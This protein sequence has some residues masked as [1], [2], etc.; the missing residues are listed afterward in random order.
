MKPTFAWNKSAAPTRLW[1]WLG[2]LCSAAACGVL[3]LATMPAGAQTML[4]D[5]PLFSSSSVPSN[6]F[7]DLS[8][9]FPTAISVSNNVP[10]SELTNFVGMFD[11]SKCYQYNLDSNDKTNGYLNSQTGPNNYF[12]PVGPTDKNH[13]CSGYWSGNFLNW[14]TSPTID[15]F[16]WAMS[17]GNRSIDTKALT[18]L[19][20]GWNNNTWGLG[21][22]LF[23]VKSISGSLVSR[24]TPFSSGS[25]DWSTLYV[26]VYNF[27]VG[28]R[29]TNPA[30]SGSAYLNSPTDTSPV[31]RPYVKSAD[32]SSFAVYDM[33]VRAKVCDPNVGLEPNCTRYGTN[34]YKPTGLIQKYANTLRF[35]A[36]S[37]INDNNNSGSQTASDDNRNGGVI[38]A[39]MKSVGPI[40]PNPGSLPKVNTHTEW[41]PTSGIFYP[42]PD[43]DDANNSA[44]TN[45][46]L[47]NYLNQFGNA[48]VSMPATP[49]HTYKGFD[50]VGELFYATTRYIKNQPVISSY[51]TLS[52]DPNIS[53]IQK[54]NFPIITT[55]EDPIQYAC[56]KNFILGI[57]DTAINADGSLPG[58]INHPKAY[59]AS[60][61]SYITRFIPPEIGADTTVNVATRT[62]QVGVME[63]INVPLVYDLSLAIENAGTF[64]LAGLAY[65]AHTVDMRP[66]DF[67]VNGTKQFI[68]TANTFWLDVM[69]FGTY[70]NTPSNVY[71]L[72]AKYGGFSDCK[73][74]NACYSAPAGFNPDTAKPGD[75]TTSMWNT[76]G[77]KA[78][79]GKLLPDNYFLTGDAQ[80]L[81]TSLNT[82][83]GKI[84]ALSATTS[85]FSIP[86]PQVQS[87]GNASYSTAYDASSWTGTLEADSLSFDAQGVV[88][89]TFQWQGR[90]KLEAQAAGTG[91]QSRI[92]ATSNSVAAGQGVP[93]ET[94]GAGAKITNSAYLTA[95]GSTT[96]NQNNLLSYLRG[97]RSNEGSNGT[98]AYRKRTYLLGD[99]VD[100]KAVP[101]GGPA[102]TYTDATNPGYA[103]FKAKYANRPS[104][105]Y[106]GANDGMLHA[107]KGD[108]T[109]GGTEAFAYVPSLLFQG[110]SSPATPTVDGLAAL[111]DPN[112]VHKFYVDLTPSVVDID[113]GNAGNTSGKAGTPNW[114]SVLIG[115]LGKG[116]KGF[117]A[118]DVTDPATITSESVLASRVLWEFTAPNMGF[119][120]GPPS[121][122]KTK[123]YGWV[124][125]VTSG[126][127]NADGIGYIYILNPINGGILE[128]IPTGIGNLTTP[129]ALGQA[130]AYVLDYTDF[131]SDSLYAGDLL[132]NVFR[133]NLTTK[134]AQLQRIASLISPSGSGQPIT[135]RPLIET[136][137]SSFKRYVFIG[138]G[139]LL[140]DS[141]IKSTQ[142]QSFYEIIDGTRTAFDTAATLPNGVT[143]PITRSNLAHL[144]DLVNGVS[145]SVATPSGFYYD[146]PLDPTA[147]IAERVNQQPTANNGIVAFAGNL[148]GGDPC[149]PQ[150]TAQIFALAYGTGKSQLRNPDNS[151]APFLL[152]TTG[153]V[154]DLQFVNVNGAI[155][156]EAGDA[157]GNVNNAAGVFDSPPGV[158][159]LNWRNVPLAD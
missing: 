147:T 127:N 38:R 21:Q 150:G 115:G 133:L 49:S 141:D 148:P 52:T 4:S 15:A 33:Q 159:R 83:F 110:P 72:G 84:N 45:S 122:V 128:T 153:L 156:L 76:T 39:R 46:G 74:N 88:T 138:T 144:T 114:H 53:A 19:Q 56:Q 125:I 27:G 25:V 29:V 57:G 47:I 5:V 67:K 86:S 134:P 124:V 71:Y 79:D 78:P 13:G 54:D 40:V 126:Y 155:R 28:M 51:T 146:L 104:M 70:Y 26:R 93:F 37:Y 58:S 2:H 151:V 99:I 152:N 121:V 149:N 107:F 81:S 7:L 142:V 109:T 63:G 16:R 41:D 154:T 22:G 61:N 113:F 112:Y 131:T 66:N 24:A 137:P 117:Y 55:P 82:A 116:G 18:V 157:K 35:G 23:P 42:N 62:S 158:R 130:S 85:S 94:T 119:T 100:S 96:T 135:T 36:L 105:V 68:T 139:K 43:F 95:L 145:T 75:I 12:I 108:L 89:K 101:I 102:A 20:K 11:P 10:Y 69:Q 32:N 90:D 3:Y 8:V 64:Y 143:W 6:V 103:A 111:A 50:P 59:V 92:I 65:D 17:G 14:A 106:V 91:W 98:R 87:S 48:Q 30:Y 132:G 118:L 97:D 140:D 73:D 80:A 123:Q 31:Y 1:G 77:N 120:Y 34:I 60:T 9:E 129:A 44:V 136:D